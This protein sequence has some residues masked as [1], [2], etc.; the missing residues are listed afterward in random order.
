MQC[1]NDSTPKG[2]IEYRHAEAGERSTEYSREALP[3][4][5]QNDERSMERCLTEA[6]PKDFG[7]SNKK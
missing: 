7:T 5:K 2:S 6:M 4:R 3:G 1:E